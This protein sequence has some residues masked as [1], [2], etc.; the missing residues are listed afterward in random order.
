MD[1]DFTEKI[2]QLIDDELSEEEAKD[3]SSHLATCEAC[4]RAHEDFLRWRGEIQS[5]AAAPD[6]IAQRQALRRIVASGKPSP[7]KRRIAL[8]VPAFALLLIAVVS[9]GIWA[10]FLRQRPATKT[11]KNPERVLTMPAPARQDARGVLDL[12]RFDRGDRAT[13]YKVRRTNQ[14][15]VEP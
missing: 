4:R 7:W 9:F 14:G 3:V 11:E 5:Y 2:S 12:A 15:G 13:L 8:P 1:C 6:L 10:A